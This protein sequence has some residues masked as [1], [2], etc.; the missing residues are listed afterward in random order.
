MPT[1]KEDESKNEMTALYI[2]ENGK[3][4]RNELSSSIKKSKSQRCKFCFNLVEKLL[5]VLFL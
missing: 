5:R 2:S 4:Q 3:E 1:T